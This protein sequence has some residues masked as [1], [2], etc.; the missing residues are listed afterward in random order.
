MN[1]L[2]WCNE[3]RRL[4]FR[5]A[6]LGLSLP[7][8]ISCGAGK[9]APHSVQGEPEPVTYAPPDTLAAKVFDFA[10]DTVLSPLLTQWPREDTSSS[11]EGDAPL[12]EA[13]AET[14]VYKVQLVTTKDLGSAQTARTK[15]QGEFKQ[16]V[17]IDFETP[18]YKV[19]VGTFSSPQA[20]EPLLQEAR[21]LGYQGAWAIKVRAASQ[22]AP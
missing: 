18:Y 21:R 20:A 4:L 2:K 7:L 15:A 22:Q 13:E 14:M 12:D 3:A 17:Q 5:A 8:A 9:T 11:R 19:R 6:A 10:Q 16:D 1:T